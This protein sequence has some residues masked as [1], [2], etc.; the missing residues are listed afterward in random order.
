MAVEKL[1]LHKIVISKP[2]IDK[3]TGKAIIKP[4]RLQFLNNNESH[5]LDDFNVIKIEDSKHFLSSVGKGV[6]VDYEEKS[7][8]ID[9]NLVKTFK[10]NLDKP[11]PEEFAQ[12]FNKY[13]QSKKTV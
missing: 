1:H 10:L 7:Y 6:W 13:E 5:V 9:D 4:H 12:V 11:V 2:A 8:S 3:D